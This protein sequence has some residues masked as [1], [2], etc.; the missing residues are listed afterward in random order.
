MGYKILYEYLKKNKKK[1]ICYAKWEDYLPSDI[2][3]VM[4]VNN[5]NENFEIYYS[6]KYNEF[7]LKIIPIT[8]DKKKCSIDL[9]DYDSFVYYL[10][11]NELYCNLNDEWKERF[12]FN[13]EI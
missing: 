6:E 7:Y 4:F 8:S 5:T 2:E 10:I 13:E 11:D 1:Y 3:K 9:Y 12:G